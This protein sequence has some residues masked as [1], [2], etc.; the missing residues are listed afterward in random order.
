MPAGTAAHTRP[1]GNA[2]APWSLP[3]W[4]RVPGCGKPIGAGAQFDLDHDD[5][6]GGYIGVSHP[7]CNRKAGATIRNGSRARTGAVADRPAVVPAE[8]TY[9]GLRSPT[10]LRWSREW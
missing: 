7:R 2:L 5:S 3:G 8:D 9:T 10:G 6:R 4:R 1:R